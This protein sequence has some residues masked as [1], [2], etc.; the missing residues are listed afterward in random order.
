MKAK[1]LKSLTEC[2]QFIIDEYRRWFACTA[3][4]SLRVSK[5]REMFTLA[6]NYRIDHLIS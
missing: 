3:P 2:E 1:T 6:K 4:A 5:M